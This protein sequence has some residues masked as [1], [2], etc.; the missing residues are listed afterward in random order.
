MLFTLWSFA[1]P[2]VFLYCNFAVKKCPLFFWNDAVKFWTTTNI[3][4]I[5]YQIGKKV[6]SNFLWTFAIYS[7]KCRFR[8]NYAAFSQSQYCKVVPENFIKFEW[9]SAG[10]STFTCFQNTPSKVRG[11]NTEK[12]MQKQVQVSRTVILLVKNN[13]SIYLFV[14]QQCFAYFR[15]HRIIYSWFT[16]QDLGSKS[17][18]V[19]HQVQGYNS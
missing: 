15:E 16:H 10:D 11:L 6:F 2:L 7:V 18:A 14:R 12:F 19:V 17:S 5:T 13:V 4:A 3:L 9:M 8:V 1:K